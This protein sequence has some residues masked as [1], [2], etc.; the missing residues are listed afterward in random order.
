M[1]HI[2]QPL[3][4]RGEASSDRRSAPARDT[5]V[6]TTARCI[7]VPYF[8]LTCISVKS[9]VSLFHSINSKENVGAA[10]E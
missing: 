3:I 6:Q 5:Q 7:I 1:S 4:R 9:D 2:P 10:H 8:A